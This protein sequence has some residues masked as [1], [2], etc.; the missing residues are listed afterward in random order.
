MKSLLEKIR[1]LNR[2][3]QKST[4]DPVNF[5]NIA[6]TL[7]VTTNSQVTLVGRKGKILSLYA[8]PEENE[9]IYQPPV[10]KTPKY[11]DEEENEKLINVMTTK[12]DINIDKNKVLT[13]VPVNGGGERLGTLIFGKKGDKFSIEDLVLF[14]FAATVTGIEILR[15]I[16]ERKERKA[17]EKESLKLAMNSLSYSEI[18]ALKLIFNDVQDKETFLI[19]SKIAQKHR[20][21]RSVIVN[22]LR[23]M[24]SAGVINARSLGMKGT[25]VKIINEYFLDQIQAV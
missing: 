13:I 22:A 11:L 1:I 25:H 10:G 6:A 2:T 18:E 14:E 4:D 12:P 16:N 15:L 3:I 9:L 20:L 7:S 5:D 19:A 8:I 23:K 24:E 21:T 17:R